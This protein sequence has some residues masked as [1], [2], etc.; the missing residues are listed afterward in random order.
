[1]GR[2]ER[3]AMDEAAHRAALERRLTV[4]TLALLLGVGLVLVVVLIGL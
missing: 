4:P 1:M 3:H 2:L